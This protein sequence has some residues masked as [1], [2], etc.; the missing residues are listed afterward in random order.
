MNTVTPA[1]IERILGFELLPH[2]RNRLV[3]CN[4]DY[5]DLTETE[6]NDYLIDVISVLTRDITQSG[7]HR[8]T[9]WENGW[10][11]NLKNFLNSKDT[12]DLIPKYHSKRKY[13]RW[14]KQIIS[15]VNK[16]FDYNIHTIFV[17]SIMSHYL[18]DCSAIFEFGCGPGYHLL[19]LNDAMPGKNYWG[20]D[21]TQASQQIIKQINSNTGT[22]INAV[23]F[24]FFSPNREFVFPENCG[25]YTVAALEQVGDKFK[26]FVDYILEK[27][28]AICVHLEPIDELLNKDEL[29]DFLS[30]KYFRK[31]NYLNGFL[32]YLEQLEKLGKIEII[33]KQRIFTGS[34]FIEGHSLV[35]WKVK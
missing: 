35:V 9:E 14:M 20:S 34:Y 16:K 22:N 6:Y 29:L 17:D 5:Y 30:I 27:R 1:Q 15:P 31:R 8:I 26:D 23:N 28:P 33:K 4:L 32:P 25:I 10:G 2:I 7:E 19:R 13:V 18:K 12:F 24:N 21:W 11:E 3:T